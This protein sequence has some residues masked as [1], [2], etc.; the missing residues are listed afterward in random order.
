MFLSNKGIIS[1][2]ATSSTSFFHV[3]V[4]RYDTM[5]QLKIVKN[6]FLYVLNVREPIILFF[7]SIHFVLK[8]CPTISQSFS[9]VLFY[10]TPPRQ[11]DRLVGDY[12]VFL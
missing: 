3:N 4:T 5:Y 11:L 6:T 2:K 1:A 12:F 9:A 10:P 7:Y 8:C